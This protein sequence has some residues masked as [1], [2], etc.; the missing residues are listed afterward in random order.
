MVN[1]TETDKENFLYEIDREWK[2]TLNEREKL[3]KLLT[4]IQNRE[5]I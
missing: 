4:K 5:I 3:N 1:R 2:L